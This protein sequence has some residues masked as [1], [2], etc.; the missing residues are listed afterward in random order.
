MCFRKR[1]SEGNLVEVR[2]GSVGM[3]ASSREGGDEYSSEAS[4]YDTYGT[5]RTIHDALFCM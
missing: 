3:S 4:E 1:F 2:E 5:V